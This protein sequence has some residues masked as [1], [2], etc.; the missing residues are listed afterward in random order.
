[1]FKGRSAPSSKGGEQSLFSVLSI[2]S[3]AMTALP[4]AVEEQTIRR[5]VE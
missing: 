5:A 4:F 1:L 2:H 3:H